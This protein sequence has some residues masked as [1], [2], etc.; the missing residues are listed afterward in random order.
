MTEVTQP[1]EVQ[2]KQYGRPDDEKV[3]NFMKIAKPA[4]LISIILTIASIF[5][6]CTK[7]LNLGLDFTG[8]I[9]A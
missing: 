2:N 3:I 6:I 4:A 1:K 5:C 8:G 9:S 7:A